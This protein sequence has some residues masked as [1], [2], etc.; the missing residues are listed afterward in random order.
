MTGPS[1]WSEPTTPTYTGPPPTAPPQGWPPP[2]SGVPYGQTAPYGYPAPYGHPVPYGYPAPYGQ[3][4]PWG[5]VPPRGPQK[6]AQVISAAVLAFVQAGLVLIASLYLWFLSSIA[7]AAVDEAGAAYSP[8]VLNVLANRGVELAVLQLVSAAA[9][10]VAGV[11][12]LRSRRRAAWL[13]LGVA[14][15][16]QLALAVYWA[17]RLD[18]L[19]GGIGTGDGVISAFSLFFAAAPLVALGLLLSGPARRWFDGTRPA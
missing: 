5:P 9:L 13:V 1:P 8:T 17:Q 15:A 18:S 16:A 7:G 6:P 4:R 3:A 12:L 19:L 2:G 10:V 14:L 11:W